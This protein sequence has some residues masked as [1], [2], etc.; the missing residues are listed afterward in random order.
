[1]RGYLHK[2]GL[3]CRNIPVNGFVELDLDTD[4]CQG[5]SLEMLYLEHVESMLTIS[6][7]VRGKIHIYLTSP[8]GTRSTLLSVRPQDTSSEGFNEWPFMTTH[9]WGEL[10]GGRWHLEVRNGD[11]IG[12][13]LLVLHGYF[14]YIYIYIILYIYIK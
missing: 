13:Y 7:S 9:N 1:L 12:M 3:A 2:K 4:G 10:P 11:S 14:L 8:L 5:T 6:T